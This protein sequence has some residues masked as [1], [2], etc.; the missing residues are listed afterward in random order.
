VGIFHRVIKSLEGAYAGNNW[1]K[2]KLQQI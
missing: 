2:H 1:T